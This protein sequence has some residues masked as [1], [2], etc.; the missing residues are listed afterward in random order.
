MAECRRKIK[1]LPKTVHEGEGVNVAVN[2]L[3]KKPTEKT[4]EFAFNSVDHDGSTYVKQW[5]VISG[6]SHNF[7][8]NK[9]QIHGNCTAYRGSVVAS[10]GDNLEVKE[11]GVNDLYGAVKLV[12][13]K[14][15]NLL[16]IGQLTK[17]MDT[18][19]IFKGNDCIIQ[20][21]NSV[22]ATAR[23]GAEH[24]YRIRNGQSSTGMMKVNHAKYNSEQCSDAYSDDDE[25]NMS[26]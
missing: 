13:R 1:G 21:D 22:T 15:K 14:G 12:P 4:I 20:S 26:V 10:G 9:V 5:I 3:E 2:K 6:S 17:K 18:A 23:K 25:D 19:V 24:L 8:N 7:T 16:S 11:K